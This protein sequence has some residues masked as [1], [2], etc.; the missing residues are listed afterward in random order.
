LAKNLKIKNSK[1]TPEIKQAD[2]GIK[3]FLSKIIQL[4]MGLFLTPTFLYNIISLR[5]RVHGGVHEF[6]L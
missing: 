2:S 6:R 1:I 4:S 3:Y 5:L